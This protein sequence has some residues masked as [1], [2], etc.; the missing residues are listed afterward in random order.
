MNNSIGDKQG[1]G[2]KCT[3]H[4]VSQTELGFRNPSHRL[5]SGYTD[6]NTA[7][8]Y[9]SRNMNQESEAKGSSVAFISSYPLMGG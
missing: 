1:N 5:V 9:S 8:G 6:W 4:P 3:R 2:V 7:S